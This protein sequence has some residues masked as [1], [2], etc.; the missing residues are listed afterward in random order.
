MHYLKRAI[1]V[2]VAIVLGRYA[3]A[4]IMNP[5]ATL[6]SNARMGEW[7][8]AEVREACFEALET[9]NDPHLPRTI[10][11]IS[12]VPVPDLRRAIEMTAALNCYMV[13][14][15]NAVCDPHNRAYIV[16]YIGKYYS[17]MDDM[18]SQ[19]KR[20]G[21]EYVGMIREFW[22]SRR[23]QDIA[24]GIEASIRDGKLA[25]SDFGWSVP[26][27]LKPVLDKYSGVPNRCAPTRSA[28]R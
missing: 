24:R 15:H 12:I 1:F 8:K 4:L 21:P 16:D 3:L 20:N 23:N 7:K 22:N 17:K 26:S 5:G 11:D 27:A 10:S 19:A 25:K 9:L 2:I 13:T 28:S 6:P 18:L 14:K